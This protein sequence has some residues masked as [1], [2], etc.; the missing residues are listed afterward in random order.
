MADAAPPAHLNQS[1]C[2]H[3]LPFETHA[4]VC[5]T[6]TQPCNLT[7]SNVQP[8][9]CSWGRRSADSAIRSGGFIASFS[10]FLHRGSSSARRGGEMLNHFTFRQDV[11]P[12]TADPDPPRVYRRKKT[13]LAPSS[14]DHTWLL[15]DVQSRREEKSKHKFWKESHR[16]TSQRWTIEKR[17]SVCVFFLLGVG[18]QQDE[19][20]LFYG[21][22]LL[23]SIKN[24]QNKH[25]KETLTWLPK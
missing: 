17:F 5:R 9:S 18:G 23:L 25:S 8:A 3:R 11:V 15:S 16:R 24:T 6:D 7:Q 12:T 13:N 19:F 14:T 20:T 10:P 1:R 21:N 22:N 4:C 2:S